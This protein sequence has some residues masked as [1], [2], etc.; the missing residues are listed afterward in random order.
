[1]KLK[2]I[3]RTVLSALL[4]AAIL[5]AGSASAISGIDEF[6]Q[7]QLEL[8]QEQ[9]RLDGELE[10]VLNDRD[11][12]QQLKETY[13]AKISATEK[14]ID[15]LNETISQYSDEI[16]E[17]E[18][19]IKKLNSEIEKDYE[20][21]G[22]RL[23]AIYM[24]GEASSLEILL[25]AKDFSDFI[26]KAYLIQS[27]SEYDN[28]LI[29]QLTEKIEKIEADKKTLSQE[30]QL[31]KNSKKE[32]EKKAKELDSLAEKCDELIKKLDGTKNALESDIEA[33][34]AQ[35]EKL[36]QEL[37]QW[38]KKY[39]MENGGVLADGISGGGLNGYIW[40]APECTV[41]TSYWGDGRNH[42]G[43]DFA[44]NGSAYGKQ[45]VA[46]QKGTVI[47][48]N[49]TDSWGSG[50][51]YYI[52][53]DHGNGFSTLYAHCSVVTVEVGQEVKQGEIIGYIGNTGDSYGAH[54]HF[55][56]WYNGE[57]YDPAVEILS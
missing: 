1:M 34:S 28:R 19:S 53:I 2:R 3:F 48:A 4:C 33:N 14:E 45:L 5:T 12:Q 16:E 52:M 25:G 27:I 15:L 56:C 43:M 55:E 54:L 17:K 39:V 42:R 26:D 38:H 31:V 40:P 35:Q 32:L 10:K 8:Q 23:R 11:K 21:L 57:R 46:A 50:W 51:G 29:A 22:K 49:K 6:V 9:E 7:R 30:Q 36:S 37:S 18:A 13:E 20:R 41:I 24:S 47:R 44:C